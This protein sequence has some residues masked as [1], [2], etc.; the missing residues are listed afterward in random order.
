MEEVVDLK[1]YLDILPYPAFVLDCNQFEPRT[2]NQNP[3]ADNINFILMNKAC[4][5]AKFGAIVA[6]EIEENQLFREWLCSNPT[7]GT[8]TQNQLF[9]SAEL[10]FSSNIL[11]STKPTPSLYSALIE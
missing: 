11:R 6:K 7:E 4:S 1:E 2:G 5:D 3:N 8:S 10:E 9:E